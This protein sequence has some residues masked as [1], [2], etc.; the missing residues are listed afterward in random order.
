MN[1]NHCIITYYQLGS[2]LSF[3]NDFTPA[4]LKLFQPF[5]K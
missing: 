1:N 4:V 2:I 3:Y 5:S